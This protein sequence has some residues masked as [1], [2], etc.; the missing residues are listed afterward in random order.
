MRCTT[1]LALNPSKRTTLALTMIQI[2]NCLTLVNKG[3]L[4][5]ATT[6]K[7]TRSAS[8]HSFNKNDKMR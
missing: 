8:L 4:R 7:F 6:E 5:L 2:S 3:F 1:T